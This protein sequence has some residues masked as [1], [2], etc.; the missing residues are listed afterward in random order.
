MNKHFI[1]ASN[2]FCTFENHISAPYLR[3][4]FDLDFVPETAEISIC[5][6]GFYIL[7]VNGVDVTKGLLAPYISNTDQYCY[8]DTY[9][10]KEHLVKGKNVIGVVL[11][12][13]MMNAFGGDVWDFDKAEN[14]GAPRVA[15]EFSASC[16]KDEIKIVAD[17]SFKVHASPITFDDLRMG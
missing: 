14:R 4:E 1:K 13:G 17:E 2:D 16:E 15:L 9:N 10:V 3:K 5:G 6:L 12:N 8:Y 7:Y 11:G